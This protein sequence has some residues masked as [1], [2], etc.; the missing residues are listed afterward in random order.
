MRVLGSPVPGIGPILHPRLRRSFRAEGLHPL[1][2]TTRFCTGV[3]KST[4][5][6]PTCA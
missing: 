5:S 6:D 4:A 1:S 3:P 2:A